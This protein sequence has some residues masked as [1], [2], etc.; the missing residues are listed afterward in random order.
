MS[1]NKQYPR[2][3][4]PFYVLVIYVLVQFFWW[5]YLMVD[6]TKTIH[7]QQIVMLG[8]DAGKQAKLQG[9]LQRKWFMIAGE[10]S[11]FLALMLLGI[12]QVRKAFKKEGELLSRQKTFLHSVTHE[13]K[14]PVASLRL[15]IETLLK[16]N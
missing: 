2:A 3:L 11:V 5:S 15:Q 12:F 8:N 7:Q 6:Q 10:G 13:F 14:S 1:E 16:R 9:E 4:L